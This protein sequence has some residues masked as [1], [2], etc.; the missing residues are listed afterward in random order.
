MLVRILLDRMIGPHHQSHTVEMRGCSFTFPWVACMVLHAS[1]VM[2]C[3][4]QQP[5]AAPPAVVSPATLNRV[6]G[7]AEAAFTAKD[8]NGAVAKIEELLKLLGPGKEAPYELLYFNIGLGHLLGGNY[9]N[10][11]TAFKD[12]FKRYPKGE[13]ASRCRL[14][15]GRACMMQDAAEKK[16]EAITSLKAA[17]LDPKYRS[18]A[19]LW[20][21][22]ILT[23]LGRHD[24][25]L[26]VFKSLIGSDVRTPQQT[27]AAVEVVGLLADSGKIEDLVVYLD[28]LNNQSG[29]R[30]SVA[31]FAFQMIERGD[32]LVNNE[33]FEP[34]LAIYRSVP[35]RAEILAIQATALESMRRDLKAL[36]A[37][38]AAEKNKGLNQRSNASQLVDTLKPA[39]QVAEEAIKKIEEKTDLD[40]ALLMRRGRCLF[41]LK[42]LEEALHCFRTVRTKY[43]NATDARSAA[44]AE[45]VL[46]NERKDT[47][48]IKERC[49][50]YLKKYPDADN[51]EQ[52]AGL[53]GEILVQ[54]GEWKQVASLYQ[55][56]ESKF[57]KSD[58]LD[59]YIFFQGLASFQDAKFNDS[60]PL[61]AKVVKNHPTS[62]LVENALYYLAM[63]DF[64][65]NKYKETLKSCREYLAKFPE[66]RYAGDMRYRLAFIDFNDKEE[67][68]SEK[69]I[70]ELGEFVAA[71]P[72]DPAAGS[73]HCLIADCHKR[74]VEEQDDDDKRTE[75]ENKAVESYKKAIWTDNP[76]DVIQYAL[77]SATAILQGRKD[78]GA[79]AALHGEFLKRKPGS[80]LALLSASWVAKTKAREGKSAEAAQML[81]DALSAR[82][83]DPSSEQ[84]EFLIDELVKTLVPRKK[85]KDIDADAVDKELQAVLAKAVAGKENPTT[86][87]RIYYARA[88]MAQMLRRNDRSDSYLKGIATNYAKDPS[89]LSA[90][91]LSVCGEILLKSGDVDGAEA[92]FKRLTDRY[93]DSMYSDAGPVGLGQVALARGQNEEALRIFEDALT[94]NPGMSKFKEASLGKLEALA[95]LSKN[96]EAV[97]F[98]LQ[99]VGDKTFRGE[100]AG[101]AYLVLGGV[102]RKQAKDL[103]GSEAKDMLAKAHGTFQRVYIA[104]Q[105]MPE[106]CAEGY[107]QAYETARDLNDA[108]LAGETLQALKNHPKLQ[109]TARV[110]GLA[111]PAR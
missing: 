41:Y 56:L 74:L 100:T 8:Y 72:E 21:G 85:P 101:K 106:I 16:E 98:A 1:G 3:G 27:T 33:T 80:S 4:A 65:S 29:V 50:D 40:A 69:I 49:D 25:A 61:F 96:E 90:A 83:G 73:I 30:D 5:P 91:L 103:T 18:E 31:W 59:R 32:G 2:H 42:R 12:C 45:I 63:S 86:N 108:V 48:A 17:A 11:E 89:G 37:R 46:L 54:A 87:A 51:I 38:V 97:K 52:V 10:A 104:Y 44:Y 7:E 34:A 14:G 24:E 70:R 105:G 60:S 26:K 68:Q 82:I 110:K 109:N 78:W 57:P 93:G 81:A 64:L 20:L 28:R 92:M 84:V 79:I 88:R 36:E 13:Y 67:D 53:A 102:Y 35:P 99:M 22:E 111:N 9:A 43:P 75:H 107:W 58:N 62:P 76:D 47:A 66:G 19:G 15:I 95:K 23:D 94:N 71:R 55:G 39:V 77:D 6:F